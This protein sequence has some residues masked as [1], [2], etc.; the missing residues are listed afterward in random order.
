MYRHYKNGYFV[1]DKGK[2]KRVRSGKLV[3]VDIYTNKYGYKYFI[4]FNTSD[5]QKVYVHRAVALLFIAQSSK[6]KLIV[7]HI[8]RNRTDNKASNLRWVNHSENAKNVG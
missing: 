4:L 6:D 5:K 2:V 1:S 7:D 3:K 8:S